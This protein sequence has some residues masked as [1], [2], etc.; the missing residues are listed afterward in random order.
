MSARKR[1][2]RSIRGR[3]VEWAADLVL[4]L[5]VL[6]FSLSIAVRYSSSRTETVAPT[7]APLRSPSPSEE[8]LR[9][10]PTVDVRNGS[11]ATG[12][13]EQMSRRLRR[14]GFDVL[15]YRTADRDD[16]ETTLVKDRTGRVGA[17]QKV[18][19]Y[20]RGAYGVG[21][22]VVDRIGTPEADVLLIL[23]RDLADTLARRE[24]ENR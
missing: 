4:I 19:D 16:Y 8:E 10:R 1:T 2:K 6:A 14:D 5:V 23:G 13:A 11:G 21:E 24:R 15:E 22:V 3:L 9:N 12:L 17:A 7:S 20:L 18:C